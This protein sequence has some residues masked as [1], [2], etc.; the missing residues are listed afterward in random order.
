MEA[1]FVPQAIPRDRELFFLL[2]KYDAFQG[3]ASGI[4]TAEQ[5]DRENEILDYQKSKPFFESWSESVH[6]DSGGKSF[7]NVRLQHDDK[8]V[9]GRLN[10]IEFN[11]AAKMIRVEAKIVDPIAKEL[12][13]TGCLT[14]FSI[15]G[16]Y[17]DKVKQSDGVI[18]YVADPCEISVVDRPALAEA[19]FQSVKGD[20]TTELRKFLS[21]EQAEKKI[22][23]LTAV[24]GKAIRYLVPEGNHLPVTDENG[25]PSHSHM[26]A[27][28]AA[29]HD[30]Y[31]G[32]KYE[33]P[34]KD[35]ALAALI[36]MYHEEG[37]ET[38]DASKAIELRLD[39]A[40][41]LDQIKSLDI[42]TLNEDILPLLKSIEEELEKKMPE[43]KDDKIIT[44]DKAAR[45]SIHQKIAAAKSHVDGFLAHCQKACGTMHGHLDGIAKVMGGGPESMHEG[46]DPEVIEHP[47]P[48]VVPQVPGGS[49][50]ADKGF[51]FV[52]VMKDGKGTG[53]FK[54]VP[55][56]PAPPTLEEIETTVAK[57]VI[58][59]LTA[60]KKAETDAI[61]DRSQVVP[62]RKADSLRKEDDQTEPQQGQNF[63][64]LVKAGDP[65]A[66]E[67]AERYAKGD[68]DAIKHVTA[69]TQNKWQPM[70]S[71]LADP[72]R[73]RHN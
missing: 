49:D 52:E 73:Y 16:R 28:W 19:V 54:K 13:E 67:I 66:K 55:V 20:G 9:A 3:I 21:H 22:Q 25:K 5:V 29:L 69:N 4:A 72:T 61:G 39:L 64:D 62:F 26:G 51:K 59:V 46:G 58:E 43:E 65:K 60:I 24:A 33:G 40:D 50:M 42:E 57:T 70:P 44:L 27:A 7:G 47:D 14:G 32:N 31:R 36:R 10:A 38:P 37:L 30:G 17:V 1:A 12:L 6:K 56:N 34:D 2:E 41:T 15:G 35:K 48:K 45:H 71:R 8:K 11:D 68:A 63:W 18:R 23:E 53:M